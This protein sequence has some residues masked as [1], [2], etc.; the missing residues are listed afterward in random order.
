M[1]RSNENKFV[2]E[3]AFREIDE[4]LSENKSVCFDATN[5]IKRD[6]RRLINKFKNK[7]D[8]IIGIYMLTPIED[9][10]KRNEEREYSVPEEIID[11]YS[12]KFIP[13]TVEEGFTDIMYINPTGTIV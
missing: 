8:N 10:K 2:F 13:P 3:L 11:I 6:R 7:V 9:C 5:V 1:F 4:A 12:K